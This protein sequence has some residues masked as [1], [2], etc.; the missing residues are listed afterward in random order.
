[1][2]LHFYLPAKDYKPFKTAPTPFYFET[3]T[4]STKHI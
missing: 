4:D 2:T 1:M 3:F